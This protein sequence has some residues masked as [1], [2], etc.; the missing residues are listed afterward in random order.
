[1]LSAPHSVMRHFTTSLAIALFLAG[2]LGSPARAQDDDPTGPTPPRLGFIDGD[3]SYWRPGAEDWAP[4]QVNTAL[5]A[6]D[7][8]Y[9]AERANVELQVGPRAFVRAGSDTQVGLEALDSDHM[10]YKVT[11][12]HAAFDLK[13]LPRGTSIELDTPSAAFEINR[14]GYYRV[15]VDDDRTVFSVRRGGLATVTPIR[16]DDAE[17]GD[18]EQIVLA[19]ERDVLAASDGGAPFQLGRA[20]DLDDWDRWNYDR[21]SRFGDAPRSA[22][23]V[24]HDVAGVDDLDRYGDWR[25]ES[26]YGRVWVPRDVAPDW[27][28]YSTGRWTYDPYYEWTWVDDAP[29]GW[30]PYHY[31]RWVH[32]N[33]Y[34]G[35]APGPVV[36][37]PVYAP[38]LVAFFGAPGIGVS[39][40]VGAPV[41]SWC[42]LGFGEPV[43]PWWG[44][45][46][47]VGRPYWGGW[48]GPRIVNDVVVHNTNIINVR[49]INRFQNAG[50]RNALVGIDRERFGRGRLQHV[51]VDAQRLNPIHGALGVRPARESLVPRAERGRRPPDRFQQ[52]RVVATRP[53]DDPVRRLRARGLE[54]PAAQSRV[55]PQIVRAR[56]GAARR[57]AEP[58]MVNAPN[59]DHPREQPGGVGA[60]REQAP[61]LDERQVRGRDRIDHGRA[62]PRGQAESRQIERATPPPPPS[63]DRPREGAGPNRAERAAPTPPR[64]F[65]ARGQE[66]P[67]SDRNRAVR[68]QNRPARAEARPDRGQPD[69]ARDRSAPPRERGANARQRRELDR[70]ERGAAGRTTPPPIAREERPRPAPRQATPREMAPPAPRTRRPETLASPRREPRREP[71]P[72]PRREMRR[73]TRREP[74]PNARNQMPRAQQEARA[75]EGRGRRRPDHGRPDHP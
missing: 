11:G 66:Q 69:V 6:G 73:E 21:T 72:E 55:Q 39:V 30:A 51:R 17:I 40:S 44:G 33:D 23:Y 19:V 58:G 16:G 61:R 57:Q 43:I 71:P 53:A 36:V 4:A 7:E 37:R 56:R 68:D 60:R 31:G 3:V 5:A 15:D 32:V 48:G 49:N 47:Y 46:R 70:P 41:V 20:P 75:S 1:M 27:S 9:A 2:F 10:Q 35:W 24:P 63:H 26:R 52:R 64:G 28:P 42:A 54:V 38:A 13:T 59:A 34:W 65:R 22:Q 8:V 50:V 74:P 25:E 62:E 67:P 12:G 45:H 29:W 14:P 18:G